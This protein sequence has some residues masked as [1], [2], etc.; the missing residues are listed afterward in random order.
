DNIVWGSACGGGDCGDNIVWGT[1]AD[2]DNIVWGTAGD[3]DNIVWGTASDII[4]WGT[5]SDGDNIV[6]GSATDGDTLGWCTAVG[7]D[8]AGRAVTGRRSDTDDGKDALSTG[9]GHQGRAGAIRAND[10]QRLAAAVAG[11]ERQAG[12]AA[13]TSRH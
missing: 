1:A 9:A 12:R 5:A 7:G 2:G 13:R 8:A 6:W 3:G 4:V 10:Q 11:A